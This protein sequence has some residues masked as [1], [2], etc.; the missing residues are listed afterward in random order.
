L[1]VLTDVC[2][3]VSMGVVMGAGDGNE[4]SIEG[5]DVRKMEER[6]LGESWLGQLGRG[7]AWKKGVV[8]KSGSGEVATWSKYRRTHQMCLRAK[9]VWA[10]LLGGTG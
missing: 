8:A 2:F 6:R 7:N 3:G 9:V 5:D 10:D 1:D 4:E